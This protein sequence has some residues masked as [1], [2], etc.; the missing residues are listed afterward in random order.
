MPAAGWAPQ[1][2]TLF[3]LLIPTEAMTKGLESSTPPLADIMFIPVPWCATNAWNNDDL[4]AGQAVCRQ[5]AHAPCHCAT[6]LT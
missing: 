3:S 4:N 5:G 6:T 1:P 2:G